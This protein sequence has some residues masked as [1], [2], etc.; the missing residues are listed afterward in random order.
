MISTE[1]TCTCHNP[2]FKSVQVSSS[3]WAEPPSQEGASTTVSPT[4]PFYLPCLSCDRHPQ[5]LH[6]CP[7][8]S[9]S[10]HGIHPKYGSV[11]AAYYLGLL[12]K[13]L[14]K[15]A[16]RATVKAFD[17]KPF[18]SLSCVCTCWMCASVWFSL[19]RVH[20]YPSIH[21]CTHLCFSMVGSW[22]HQAQPGIPDHP[23]STDAS[24]LLLL[25]LK[26]FPGQMGYLVLVPPQ[27][28]VWLN[29]PGKAPH[30][31]DVGITFTA[32]VL[33]LNPNPLCISAQF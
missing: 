19:F 20:F 30:L 27:V 29:M 8:P 22:W 33:L 6:G 14:Q 11:V 13:P 16:I 21:P 1:D 7:H 3:K 28:V 10:K 31:L 23:L 9:L 26:V 15:D 12:P 24:Q 2:G 17:K 25:D 5:L 32:P 18:S 4:E